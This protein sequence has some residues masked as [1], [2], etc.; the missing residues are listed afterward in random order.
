MLT[1]ELINRLYELREKKREIEKDLKPIEAEIESLRAD[2]V[3]RFL[4]EKSQGSFTDV[5]TAT[6]TETTVCS[7]TDWDAFYQYVK[8]NDAFY[9]LQR[10][11]SN[12]AWLELHKAGE[13]PPG[14][15]DFTK[16]DVS[17][18]KRS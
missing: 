3:T 9:L 6:L 7:V 1:S 14:T 15:T 18:R 5:A 4:E 16:M 13:T 10:R 8:D 2:L 11:V 17:L 12:P